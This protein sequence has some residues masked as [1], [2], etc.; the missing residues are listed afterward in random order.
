MKIQTKLLLL[1]VLL[2]VLFLGGL[3]SLHQNEKEQED[4]FI[5]SIERETYALFDKMLVSKGYS[6]ELFTFDYSFWDD[7]VNF[8]AHPA[9]YMTWARQMLNSALS[10]YNITGL[11]LYRTNFTRVY[12]VNNRNDKQ[13]NQL[14]LTA[15]ELKGIFT[16]GYFRHFFL[17]L[18]AG[19]LEIR[20]APIQP[21]ADNKRVTKPQGFL[22]A[23]KLWDAAYLQ[24]LSNLTASEVKITPIKPDESA[25]N[26]PQTTIRFRKILTGWDG[27]ALKQLLIQRNSEIIQRVSRFSQVRFV[28]S[29]IFVIAVL[30]LLY[31]LLVR[32]VGRP[33]KTISQS[34]NTEN[35]LLL[36]PLLKD[37][38]EMG[39]VAR[40]ID[41]FFAQHSELLQ[42]INERKITEAELRESRTLYQDLLNNMPDSVFALDLNGRFTFA[43]PM[44]EKLT[45]YPIQK[46]LTMNVLD[47]LAPKYRHLM[48]SYISQKVDWGKVK[49][50]TVE[51]NDALGNLLTLQLNISPIFT[52]KGGL[53]GVQGIA[54]DI[55]QEKVLEAKLL[56]VQKMEAVGN[57]AG[58]IAHD[59]NNLLTAIR[60]NLELA[61]K[62]SAR[63][64]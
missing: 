24:E 2:I 37:R 55:T 33:L 4:L 39:S 48:K 22:L 35:P 64:Q 1:L 54:H 17:V 25:E 57:L 11:W 46:L 30:L 49:L 3:V 10:P 15:K 47:L 41:K 60:G 20:T 32:W 29:I 50:L 27:R 28:L 26:K 16:Q 6:L 23:G 43:S 21:S 13:L 9:R 52:A 42:E 38:S 36:S 63:L 31:I 59:F 18:P 61:K 8:V 40:T 51:I 58:G 53:M 56:Q 45:G 34:L 19:L 44:A 14:P 7:L 5:L 12:S 62:K